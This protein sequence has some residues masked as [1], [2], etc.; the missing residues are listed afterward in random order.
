MTRCTA[1]GNRFVRVVHCTLCDAPAQLSRAAC[2]C[3]ACAA[4][5][6]LFLLS[7]LSRA[8]AQSQSG[9]LSETGDN[10]AISSDEMSAMRKPFYDVRE[11]Q[12]RVP[13]EYF[14]NRSHLSCEV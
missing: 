2:A 6:R 10:D 1:A 4:W 7:S 8:G 3:V 12:S 14:L 13:K 5:S 11:D 9:P